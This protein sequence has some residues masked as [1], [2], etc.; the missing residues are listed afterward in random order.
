MANGD[1]YA[2]VSKAMIAIRVAAVLATED[3]EVMV[4]MNVVAVLIKEETWRASAEKTEKDSKC[5]TI[6]EIFLIKST[7]F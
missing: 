7:T 4:I 3:K 1:K 2:V 6:I 5:D